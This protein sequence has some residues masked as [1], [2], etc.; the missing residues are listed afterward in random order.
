MNTVLISGAAGF[1]AYSLLP[2]LVATGYKKLILLD[3]RPI[4]SRFIQLL[5]TMGADV[6]ALVT[7][8]IPPLKE[9][10]EISI[11]ICLAGATSV[12][13]A[14]AQPASAIDENMHIALD[15]SE[16]IRCC[17]LPVRVVYMSSDEV[18]GESFVALDE[19]SPLRPTQPYAA[20]KAA[21]EIVLHSYRDVYDLD[22]ITLRSCNL[23]GPGQ[24][25]PK[26]LPVVVRCLLTNEP[27]PVH[28]S[29]K[30]LREWMDVQDLCRAIIRLLQSDSPRG[31]YQAASGSHLSV[32]EVIRLVADGLQQRTRITHVA[33]RLVQDR[34]YAMAADRL[35]A[36]GWKP[37]IDP[38]QGIQAAATTLAQM[39]IPTVPTLS[40]IAR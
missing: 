7:D 12:D 32:N 40:Y 25:E 33:D 8:R 9:R 29:G 20:S 28:G 4:P 24:Q 38:R 15:L 16:W 23:V 39:L 13:A 10:N 26:L 35:Q 37:Q 6:K 30:Q 2:L 3:K 18:L 27:V 31:I 22:I 17:P 21:A 11:A 5:R 19:T 36:L 1:V 34:C 14:L